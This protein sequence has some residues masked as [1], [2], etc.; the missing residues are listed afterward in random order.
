MKGLFE[1]RFAVVCTILLAAI[2]LAGCTGKEAPS[3]VLIICG[4]HS[5][6]NLT[7]MTTDT[8]SSGYEYLEPQLSPDGSTIIFTADWSAVPSNE[9][10]PEGFIPHERRQIATMP[11]T[12]G[13][14]TTVVTQVRDLGATL[15]RMNDFDL[16]FD[17]GFS[18]LDDQKGNP[19]WDFRD[20]NTPAIIFWINTQRGNRLFRADLTGHPG[21]NANPTILYYEEGDFSPA[22]Y[23]Y[24][25]KSPRL[26]PDGRWLAFS[27]SWCADFED[28]TCSQQAIWVLDME[29]A[30]VDPT[31]YRCFPVVTEAAHCDHASWSHDTQGDTYRIVFSATVD[32]V[33][34]TADATSEI[35]SLD[36]DPAYAEAN[37]EVPLDNN[38][39]RLTFTD[40]LDGDPI[41]AV[42]NYS[43]V[44]SLDDSEVYFIS[45]R[46]A[47]SITQHD[48]NIWWVPS[49]GSLDPD[50]LFFTRQDDTDPFVTDDGK[51]MFSS[52]MGFPTEML[53][54]LEEQAIERIQQEDPTLSE[55]EVLEAA[56]TE[57]EELEFF[58][59]VMSHIYVFSDW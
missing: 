26:S 2:L 31:Q 3:E 36:F 10:P 44:F 58:A 37:D 12:P 45:T 47:P 50:I 53:D 4:N 41:V 51:L 23:Y 32:L 20:P 43:P 14:S 34:E 28:L 33:G 6:G 5:C 39:E 38:L 55:F 54:Q 59:D 18:P 25:H 29:T 27:R 19:I 15:I 35:F 7:M 30:G 9:R 22:G 40:Y 8:T 46:R 57:R 21:A 42:Q 13:G 24:Q 17:D 56:A 52:K 1:R 49:D 11:F 48:R 16:P